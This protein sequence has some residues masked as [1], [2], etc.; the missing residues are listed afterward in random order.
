MDW[1]E[2]TGVLLGSVVAIK[3]IVKWIGEVNLSKWISKK[4]PVESAG[5]IREARK[6][7]QVTDWLD[8]RE[9]YVNTIFITIALFILIWMNVGPSSGVAASRGDIAFVG[10][11]L[12][13][14]VRITHLRGR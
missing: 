3:E 6:P 7:N 2:T 5:L 11:M 12:F 9:N 10:L 4:K 1:L 13:V 14:V 8:R